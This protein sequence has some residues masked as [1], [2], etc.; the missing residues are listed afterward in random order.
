MSLLLKNAQVI[1]KNSPAHSKTVNLLIEKGIITSFEGE[2]ATR[3]IDLHGK[4]ITYGWFDLNAHFADPGDEHREDIESGL[5]LARSGGFTDICLMPG[6]NPPVESKSDINYLNKT[7]SEFVDVHVCASLSKNQKGD[8]LTEILDLRAAGAICFS[9]GDKP[10][11]NTELLL[12]ALQYTSGIGAPIF[13]NARDLNLS[14]NTHMNEGLESTNL[15]LR[16]E[17]AFS[18]KLLVNR[19]LEVL[20]YAG[21]RLHFSRISTKESVDLI[22]KAKGQGVSITCDVGIHHLLF[23]DES[24][25]DFDTNFKSFPHYRS[26]VDRQALLHGV[27]DGTID[28]ICSN[29]RPLDGESK[30]LEFDLAEPGNIS[31]QTFYTSLLSI[32]DEIPFETLIDAVVNGPRK[33]L[34]EDDKSIDIG[35]EARLTILDP[36][37]TWTLNEESNLSKSI[38]SPFWNQDLKGQV[39]GIVKDNFISIN[40][41][42]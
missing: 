3:E 6:T 18:E 17:P 4:S 14:A 16:G 22:R 34:G 30:E 21:G 7:R 39:V 25:G 33:V 27:K 37:A 1:D 5:A 38:N 9:D 28:A 31:L 23:T 40:E 12:K 35:I 2:S 19:D 29:H 32:S 20:K 13:Q 42:L 11:W 41:D 15:G 10:I 8:N 36:S 24:I 26:E